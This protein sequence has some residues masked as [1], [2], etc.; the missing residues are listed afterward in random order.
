[1]YGNQ[2]PPIPQ[3]Y[4]IGDQ[5]SCSQQQAMPVAYFAGTRKI[6]AKAMSK[7]YN[8]YTAPAPNQIPTKK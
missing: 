4:G 1:M 8:L 2:T 6:S 7:T 3:P 5:M